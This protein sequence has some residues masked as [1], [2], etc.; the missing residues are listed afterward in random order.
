M[1]VSRVLL[2]ISAGLVSS[3]SVLAAPPPPPGKTPAVPKETELE[4]VRVDRVDNQTLHAGSVVPLDVV[5][6]NRGTV[7]AT[8][9]AGVSTTDAKQGVVRS[10]STSI[11]AGASKTIRVK[12]PITQRAVQKEKL[13]IQAF[14]A[15]PKTPATGNQ[16][17]Q[18]FR[19]KNLANNSKS[20]TY[21]VRVDLYDVRIVWRELLVKN[22]CSPGAGTTK[23][24]MG[25]ELGN[26]AASE[27]DPK[28]T[29]YDLRQSFLPRP[30]ASFHWPKG[31]GYRTVSTGDKVSL[32]EELV[33]MTSVPKGRYLAV[34]VSAHW[35]TQAF[36]YNSPIVGW[37]HTTIA[38]STWNFGNTLRKSP[39]K[40]ERS[41][42]SSSFPHDGCGDSPYEVELQITTTPTVVI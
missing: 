2:S 27:S 1:R 30:A 11:A 19:D 41:G 10:A 17:Q 33:K 20:A 36:S 26:L 7:A 18:L 14:V 8:V 38:P 42:A 4:L 3:A 40:V 35:E 16:L 34:R 21:A 25:F 31:G 15:D 23:W 9:A 22:D 12:L 37:V 28:G 29:K 32:H 39:E 6:A 24:K 5:I 13:T